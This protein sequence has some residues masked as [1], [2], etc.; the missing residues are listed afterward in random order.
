MGGNP[1]RHFVFFKRD[2]EQ[3]QPHSGDV[4]FFDG[5]DLADPVGRIHDKVVGVKV[6]LLAFGHGVIPMRH[7]PTRRKREKRARS[8]AVIHSH[9]RQKNLP[10]ADCFV[11]VSGILH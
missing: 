1:Q 10:Q 5:N 4:L 3:F 7:S 6:W 9:T 11:R 8:P 2:D